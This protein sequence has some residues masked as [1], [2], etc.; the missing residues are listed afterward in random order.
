MVVKITKFPPGKAEGA[1]DLRRWGFNRLLGGSGVKGGELRSRPDMADRWLSAS[2]PKRAP[3]STPK[4]R[5]KKYAR[6]HKASV[7]ANSPEA[8]AA[9]GHTNGSPPWEGE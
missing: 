5:K 3:T 4:R 1:D 7:I 8:M 9:V 6:K 2:A